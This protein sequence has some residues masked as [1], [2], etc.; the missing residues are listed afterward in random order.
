VIEVDISR[1]SLS[2][3]RIYAAFGVAE[4]WR[5]DGERVRFYDL[6]G[7]SYREIA[8]SLALPPMTAG[9]AGA[10]LDLELDEEDS[11]AWE[12]TVREWVRERRPA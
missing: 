2:R 9:Q 3:F 1:S 5:Y 8:D 4:I 10:F 6:T 11:L 7:E 12:R